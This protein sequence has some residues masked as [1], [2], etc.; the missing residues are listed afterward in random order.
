MAQAKQNKGRTTS[1]AS[2]NVVQEEVMN[3]VIEEI[4]EETVIEDVKDKTPVTKASPSK[5]KRKFEPSDLIPCTNI[6]S[7]T[8]VMVGQKSGI[9]YTWREL[10]QTEDV[11][12]QDVMAE[13]LKKTSSYIYEPLLI[14]EDKELLDQ[15]RDLKVF[16]DRMYSPAELSNILNISSPEKMRSVIMNLPK[17]VQ[18]TIKNL[19]ATMIQNGTLDSVRKIKIIDEIF[20]TKLM[21]QT[22]LFIK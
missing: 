20:E 2:K 5:E 1:K 16:Y 19:A 8:T 21:M 12:Y 4:V 15:R 22:E 7:G 6:F 9:I 11:E 3:E 18:E 13:I 17:G 10:G 14:I